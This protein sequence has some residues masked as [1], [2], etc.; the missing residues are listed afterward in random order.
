MFTLSLVKLFTSKNFSPEGVIIAEIKLSVLP[1][2]SK[3]VP[4]PEILRTV[5]FAVESL[6]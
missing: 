4:P 6:A 1:L 5:R 3:D 2:R